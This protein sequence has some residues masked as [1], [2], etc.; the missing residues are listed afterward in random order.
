METRRYCDFIDLMLPAYKRPAEDQRV[1]QSASV[2]AGLLRSY[3]KKLRRVV[4]L[5]N[6][7]GT[8]LFVALGDGPGRVRGDL[9][10]LSV[11]LLRTD[12]R[13]QLPCWTA[14]ARRVTADGNALYA[15]EDDAHLYLAN[16]LIP[17]D[18]L[19]DLVSFVIE[20]NTLPETHEWYAE[21]LGRYDPIV[22]AVSNRA[23][24]G[25]THI[26]HDAI[27]SLAQE[28]SREA[29]EVCDAE[30]PSQENADNIPF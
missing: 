27:A 12:A 24:I 11:Y 10:A 25:P 15:C 17:I 14:H 3:A 29:S 18:E 28:F 6:D 4:T 5:T 19:V 20:N 8:K 7:C 16:E 23:D 1:V 13:Q 2:L 21:N 26:L 9:G 30:E 22:N